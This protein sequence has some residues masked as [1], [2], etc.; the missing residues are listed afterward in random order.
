MRM[1]LATNKQLEAISKHDSDCPPSLLGEVVHEM[2]NR[3]LFDSMIN[4]CFQ[5]VFGSIKRIKE[6]YKMDLEDF[7]QIG[8]TSIFEAIKRFIPGKG[9]AFSSFAFMVVKHKFCKYIAYLEAEKR[10]QRNEFSWNDTE[11]GLDLIDIVTNHINVE[12][13]VINKVTIE[14]LLNQ[15]GG[16]QR[17]IVELFIKGYTGVEIAEMTGSGSTQSVNK[18]YHVALQKM[19]RGA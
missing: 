9:K 15:I 17:Q 2:L 16:R 19:R 13:Y 11:E 14:N 18:S 5:M 1:H 3:N 7:L 4:R 6:L 12:K 8:R 10:D